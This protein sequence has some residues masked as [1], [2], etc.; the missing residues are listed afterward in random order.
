MA[1]E[2]I[3]W[4]KGLP[5]RGEIR[6]IARELGISRYAAAGHFMALMEWA[7][8]ETTDGF[9][10]G[11]TLA[12][13]DDAAGCK[14]F[15]AALSRPDVAWAVQ[16]DR[17][18]TLAKFGRHNG[19]TAKRRLIEAERKQQQRDKCPTTAGT[20]VPPDAGQMSHRT[21]DQNERREEK[22]TNTKTGAAAPRGGG[23][24]PPGDRES[25]QSGQQPARAAAAAEPTESQQRLARTLQQE[26]WTLRQRKAAELAA[27]Y[28][29]A[30]IAAA[31]RLAR[32]PGIKNPGGCLI[33][34]LESGEAAEEASSSVTN[35]QVKRLREDA[36]TYLVRDLG[37]RD[38]LVAEYVTET[39]AKG[40]A[41]TIARSGDFLDW[42]AATLTRGVAA[43]EVA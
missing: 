37:R 5:G 33:A 40:D 14:G 19:E 9:L 23:E 10:R 24:V 20:N 38:R 15:G 16:D 41:S 18:V 27:T 42:V 13:L 3:K 1:R 6:I 21:R 4:V 28:P 7:D 8:D 35:G 12:D 2:W 26:P 25:H 39:G 11:M 36:A 43:A 17:G 32:G 30:E 34:K 29:E 22:N 31:M